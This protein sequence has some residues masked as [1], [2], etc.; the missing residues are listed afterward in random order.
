MFESMTPAY[1]KVIE[2]LN[3][4]GFPFTLHSHEPV[5][6]IE[7]AERKAKHLTHNLLKTVV[8]RI[9]NSHWILAAVLGSDRIDYK[10]LGEAFGV[11][12][13]ELR[14]VSPEE[15][16]REL[17]FEVGGVGPFPVTEDV[18]VVI[19]EKLVGI[20]RIFCG[21]GVNTRTV[22]MRLDDLVSVSRARVQ[23]ITR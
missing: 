5:Q 19:D 8:F 2:L 9:K 1:E 6:T 15:V 11:K 12:R 22:E 14:S 17:G 4:S 10:R 16:E 18:A 3:D 13:T 20:D 23:P 7:D 21:S